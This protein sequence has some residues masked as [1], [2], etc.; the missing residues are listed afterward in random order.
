MIIALIAQA[1]AAVILLRP[2]IIDS[3]SVMHYKPYVLYSIPPY[4]H[5]VV[6]VGFTQRV[7][8]L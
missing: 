7:N 8:D 2:Q 4:S 1:V 3:H 6:F 5:V